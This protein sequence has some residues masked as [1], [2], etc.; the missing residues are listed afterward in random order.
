MCEGCP[1]QS[2]ADF[3]PNAT[4]ELR[5]WHGAAG[6]PDNVLLSV[7]RDG[8]QFAV[9]DGTCRGAVKKLLQEMDAKRVGDCRVVMVD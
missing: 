1:L 8:D 9:R 5:I 3:F 6:E 4:T 2:L 7:T